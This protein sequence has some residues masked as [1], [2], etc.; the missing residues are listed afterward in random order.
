VSDHVRDRTG[1]ACSPE[2]THDETR[3]LASREYPPYP[4]VGVG[5]LIVAEGRIALVRRGQPPSKGEW[6][7][8]GGLVNVG[9]TLAQAV[10]REAAEETSLQVEPLDLVELLERVFRDDQ[11]RVRYHYVLAD[12]L[13]RVAGG[14]L[15][16]GSDA[17]EAGWFGRG[18][19]HHLN[20]APITLRVILKA[21][22]ITPVS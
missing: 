19:L 10:I 14:A 13:C 3:D 22:D 17:A 11:G 4:L 15:R 18:E 9:E 8:P 7:I 21:L 2:I 1:T 5:A 12:Y 16:A 6:S 20:L